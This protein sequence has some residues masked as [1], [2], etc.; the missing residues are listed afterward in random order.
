MC[1]YTITIDN[2]TQTVT[3]TDTDIVSPYF[4]DISMVDTIILSSKNNFKS[5]YPV[6]MLLWMVNILYT[7]TNHII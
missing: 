7:M 4:N 5:N 2:A 1:N 3:V 6:N